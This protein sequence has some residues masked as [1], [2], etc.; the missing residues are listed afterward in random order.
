VLFSS[1][2]DELLFWDLPRR[3][4]EEPL[5]A[6]PLGLDVGVGVSLEAEDTGRLLWN[7][8]RGLEVVAGDGCD[9][10]GLSWVCALDG[11]LVDVDV[12]GAGDESERLD[13]DGEEEV[14]GEPLAA[15]GSRS[16]DFFAAIRGLGTSEGFSLAARLWA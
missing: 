12:D 6:R 7:E 3:A 9:G 4:G 16:K 13:I 11:G 1:V 2:D 8:T 14:A 5:R 15:P 10:G